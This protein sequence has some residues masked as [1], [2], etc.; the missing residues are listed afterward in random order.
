MACT[1]RDLTE[2]CDHAS[3]NK[4]PGVEAMFEGLEISDASSSAV[5]EQ[6][7]VD[8]VHSMW[9]PEEVTEHSVSEISQRKEQSHDVF[10]DE[11]RVAFV[12][13]IDEQQIT[14]NDS[15]TGSPRDVVT[16][17]K[18][19][20]QCEHNQ[21]VTVEELDDENNETISGD[22]SLLGSVD[23]VSLPTAGIAWD[24]EFVKTDN[25]KKCQGNITRMLNESVVH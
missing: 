2:T 13:P 7:D 23:A 9:D 15:D 18:Y 14:N 22:E 5:G 8:S 12:K 25:P 6:K 20:K 16:V 4:I 24:V 19:T 21:V 17:V 10:C 11:I 3:G 1:N